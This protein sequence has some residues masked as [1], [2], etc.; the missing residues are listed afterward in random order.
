MKFEI[1]LVYDTDCLNLPAARG[2]L[3]KAL[4]HEGLE[5]QWVEY[6]RS[7]P[8]TPALLL[9]FGSP[10]ILVD[11]VD[12]AGEAGHAAAAASCRVYRGER[13]LSGV[14]SAESIAVAIANRAALAITFPFRTANS[15][16]YIASRLLNVHQD[17]A[18]AELVLLVGR[19]KTFLN[20]NV[21]CLRPSGASIAVAAGLRA[22]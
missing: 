12:V 16:A 5:P 8:G 18:M 2:A 14:P 7:A 10:T 1:T 15:A 4:E 13:G 21:S 17:L 22:V 9:R 19:L 11:G 3:R 20:S 6:D